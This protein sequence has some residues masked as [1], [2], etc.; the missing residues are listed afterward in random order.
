MNL[1]LRFPMDEQL[2]LPLDYSGCNT[3][4]G[5]GFWHNG[6]STVTSG[7]FLTVNGTLPTWTSLTPCEH[8]EI[9]TIIVSK[10]F[11]SL[12]KTFV[13]LFRK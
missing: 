7:S 1:D 13:K 5:N 12:F 2:Q 11:S 8:I 9:K 3:R 6:A 10:P 4:S